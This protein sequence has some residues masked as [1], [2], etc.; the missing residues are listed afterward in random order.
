MSIP[1]WLLSFIGLLWGCIPFQALAWGFEVHELIARQA[2]AQLVPEARQRVA[3]W[4]ALEPGASL[5]S[6]STW[7][8]KH[9]EFPTSTWHYVNF[10]KGE[11]QYKQARDCPDGHCVIEAFPVQLR[12]LQ[13]SKDPQERLR[14]L[15]FVVH[16]LSDVHQP[17]HAAWGEDRGGNRFQL[18]AFGR[19]SNLHAFWDSTL[20]RES[21]GG[22]EA[23]E[24]DV[25]AQVLLLAASSSGGRGSSAPGRSANQIEQW[26]MESCRIV[27]EDGFYPKTRELDQD[28][29][30]RYRSTLVRRIALASRR[31]ADTLNTVAGER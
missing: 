27:A 29:V 21:E 1:A 3:D 25:K 22:L 6:I 20:A 19:G 26:A 7:A 17:L 10:P 4:L 12:I 2:Q 8:D 23:I 14:A 31:L 5:A 28:Y 13:S 30:Q 18:Q 11:C 15:K 24:K 16:L 9:R